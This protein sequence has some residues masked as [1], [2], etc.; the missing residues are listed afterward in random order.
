MPQVRRKTT[1]LN[2]AKFITMWEN[3]A[4]TQTEIA[5]AFRCSN[6]LVTQTARRLKLQFPRQKVTRSRQRQDYLPTP[7]EIAAACK[8]IRERNLKMSRD[9]DAATNRGGYKSKAYSGA[10]RP[11]V[12]Y[13]YNRKTASFSG[14][15]GIN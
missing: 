5:A 2:E 14:Y 13:S 10:R 11:R 8:E 15:E 12:H 3:P 7:E 6:T 4:Y 9:Q 1:E